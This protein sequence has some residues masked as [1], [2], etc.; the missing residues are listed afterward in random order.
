MEKTFLCSL[1]VE[2]I[3]NKDT[4]IWKKI[5]YQ[6]KQITLTEL[7]KA[8]ENKHAFCGVYNKDYFCQKDKTINNW[9]Q[10]NIISVDFDNR[11]MSFDEF[12]DVA[13]NDKF[14]PSILYN[15]QNDGI[16]GN[17]YRAL[18]LFNNAIKDIPTYQ[19]TYNKI[20][21]HW[22]Q[23]TGQKNK[24]NCGG[25]VTQSMAG[26]KD[27]LICF[28]KWYNVEYF[29]SI[30][31]NKNTNSKKKKSIIENYKKEER[32]IIHLKDTFLDDYFTLKDVELIEKYIGQFPSVESTPL[33]QVPKEQ[34][35]I[36]LPKDFTQIK[37]G[38]KL[39]ATPKGK[40]TEIHKIK[41]GE[42][43]RKKLFINAILRRKIWKEIPFNNL[44]FNL[45]CE[46]FYNMINDGNKITR[47]EIFG[48]AKRAYNED[49]TIYDK[50]TKKNKKKWIV[51]PEYCK[52][53]NINKNAAKRVAV[54]QMN[55]LKIKDIYNRELTD[56]Q[57]LELLKNKGIKITLIT[58]KRWKA[59][60]GLTKQRK[61]QDDK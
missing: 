37:R 48:I 19:R 10:S 34:A 14:K 30:K 33:P 9:K 54:Q 23:V 28:N 36:M 51:N 50:F 60:D 43:R 26:N 16:K 57:N 5:K 2:R 52:E 61:Q 15:T 38:W 39:T 32:N 56:K 45:F 8:I 24:D 11:Q 25:V 12:A 18:Y 59:R 35:F 21:S 55:D 49:I 41:D 20:V 13:S 46:F 53:N 47:K 1:S 58:L 29:E 42:H 44:L 6:T 4:D 3:E 22:E 27:K 7:I 17:R 31:P 40:Y